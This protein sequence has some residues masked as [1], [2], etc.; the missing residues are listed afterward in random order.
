MFKK[1]LFLLSLVTFTFGCVS[2]DE[3]KIERLMTIMGLELTCE[4]DSTYLVII[5]GSGCANCIQSAINEI[6]EHEDTIYI[7][8]CNSEK[9]FYLQSGG[10]KASS[11]KNLYLDKRR[12]SVKLDLVSTYPQ[13]YL[14]VDGRLVSKTPHKPRNRILTDKKLTIGEI[15]K[16]CIDFGKVRF[17]QTY[18]DSIYIENK[19]SE[20]LYINDVEVSCNCTEVK[21]VQ[22]VVAPQENTCLHVVFQ[23]D[24]IGEF[25][26]FIYVNCN[27]MNGFMEIPIKG[28]SYQ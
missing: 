2:D 28:I 14:F 11:F 21:I 9:D 12:L 4:L 8:T 3:R 5:P 20:C 13:V 16:A 7:F 6:R 15:N 19:G 17:G 1:E 25:E 23:P 22:K 18:V 26:R 10:Q 27:V 24:V